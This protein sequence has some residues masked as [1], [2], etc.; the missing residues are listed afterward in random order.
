MNNQTTTNFPIKTTALICIILALSLYRLLP[1][2][3]NFTPVMAMALFAGA[4]FDNKKLAFI[5]PI[6][7]MLLS[8]LFLGF[9]NTIIFVYGAMLFSVVL[10]L[11]IQ[12][13]STPLNVIFASISGSIIFFLVT[14]LGVWLMNDFYPKNAQGLLQSYT[15]ALP[16]FQRSLF[17]DLF[18]NGV[19]FTSFWYFSK[20]I[21]S[22]N[23]NIRKTLA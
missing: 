4:H 3:L 11:F 14:N 19:L 1:H 17:G 8:D 22:H 7:A 6:A 9:H 15:M 5:I 12:K 21:L 10:G 13:K 18:F 16:F 20:N 2:P 23:K